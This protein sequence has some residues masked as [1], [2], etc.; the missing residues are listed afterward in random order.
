[1]GGAKRFGD[2]IGAERLEPRRRAQSAGAIA[3]GFVDDIPL[4]D[5]AFVMTDDGFDVRSQTLQS[6]FAAGGF[7][8]GADE[9]P[10]GRLRMPN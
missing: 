1:M 6:Q 8:I 7:A 9:I 10:A 5:A 4:F 3:D 2:I